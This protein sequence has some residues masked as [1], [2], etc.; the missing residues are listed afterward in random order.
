MPLGLLAHIR[1]RAG[2]SVILHRGAQRVQIV[3]ANV[4]GSAARFVSLAR[5]QLASVPLSHGDYLRVGG[6]AIA[7]SQARLQLSLDFILALVAI[8]ALLFIVLRDARTVGLLTVNLPF[9]LVGGI[10]AI[11][12]ARLPISL[13]AAV[14]F[15]TVFGITLRNAIMLLSHYRTLVL[16]EGRPWTLET[17][18]LG[19]MH[20][21][22][23]ILMT[24]AVTALGLLPLALGAHR[25]GQEIEGPMAMV[26][27]GGLFSSTALTLLVLPTLALRFARFET[28]DEWDRGTQ[29]SGGRSVA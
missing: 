22:A 17:A 23:P 5:R 25:A 14:G 6:T 9:A 4:T 28:T 15:V 13:G 16:E 21:M 7:S 12:V 24:A 10:A 19:A 3:T 1:E 8:L 29:I 20:R 2:Q 26:I 27:L 18:E 11:W